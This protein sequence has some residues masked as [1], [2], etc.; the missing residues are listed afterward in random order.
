M[1]PQI[2]HYTTSLVHLSL[3]EFTNKGVTQARIKATI[4]AMRDPGGAS[5]LW[6][7]ESGI[8]HNLNVH[9]LLTNPEA[10]HELVLEIEDKLLELSPAN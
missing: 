7:T 3:E 1:Q 8:N 10:I 5:N 4:E 9:T 6:C 2:K